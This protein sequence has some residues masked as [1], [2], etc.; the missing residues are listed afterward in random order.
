MEIEDFKFSGFAG[1]VTIFIPRDNCICGEKNAKLCQVD[2][3][4]HAIAV[5]QLCEW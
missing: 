4:T 1:L 5:L 3:H 2:Q